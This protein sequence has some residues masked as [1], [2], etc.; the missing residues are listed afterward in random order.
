[1]PPAIL[2]TFRQSIEAEI[3][4]IRK[5]MNSGDATAVCSQLHSLEGAL[6]VFQHSELANSAQALHQEIKKT[7]IQQDTKVKIEHLCV[8]L[9]NIVAHH[10]YMSR[11]E[12]LSQN[13]D[14][15]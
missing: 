4:T 8:A 13:S 10:A 15:L 1:M 7:G 9:E 2:E 14:I 3:I 12:V 6:F 11:S 5:A